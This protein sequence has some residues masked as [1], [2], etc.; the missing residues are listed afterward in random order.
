MLPILIICHARCEP[1]G[2]LCTYFDKKQ[3]P[4]KKIYIDDQALNEIKLDDIAG[5]ILMGGPHSVNDEHSW[6]TEELKLIQQVVERELPL[7][8][9]C[10][11]AQMISK[12]LGGNV[13]EA[14]SME[15]GWHH[16]RV[17]KSRLP[18]EL[19]TGLPESFEVFQWHEDTFSNPQD[20]IP[21]F[22]G[23]NIENQGYI[24]GK[25]L[26]MQFHLEMT[27]YMVQ[28]WLARYNDC[29]PMHLHSVQSPLEMTDRLHE[30]LENLHIIADKIYGWWLG[31]VKA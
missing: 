14:H 30:R 13:D 28:E 3:V 21:L 9:V 17:D 15:T 5:L 24:L 12:A 29:L 1:P 2:Y 18:D 22:S 31:Y 11:G 4:Y 7:M 6:I 8:G 20:S 16:I 27:E 10:F 23:S 19:I 26:T 25:V